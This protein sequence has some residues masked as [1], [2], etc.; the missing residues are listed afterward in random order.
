MCVCVCVCVCV[1][2][3]AD[4]AACTAH[5]LWLPTTTHS[6]FTAY[7]TAVFTLSQ[8]T[9]IYIAHCAPTTATPNLDP[10]ITSCTTRAVVTINTNTN[11]VRNATA[12]GRTPS[13]RT[14]YPMLTSTLRRRL[15]LRGSTPLWPLV[16]RLRRSPRARPWGESV[17]R[18]CCRI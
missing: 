14:K 6:S 7:P 17:L 5:M 12:T 3:S 13:H 9:L 11:T 10:S 2:L 16:R 15:C 18:H 4:L 1:A 8:S